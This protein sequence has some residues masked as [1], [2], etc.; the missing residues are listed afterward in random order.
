M[1]EI[2][3]VGTGDAFGSGGRRNSAILVRDRGRTLLLDCGPTTLGGLKALGIDPLELDAIAL[4]HF[5]G[6]HIAGVPFVLLDYLYE[7]PRSTPLELLGP[8]GV[9][10]RVA[11]L[12]RAY[13]YHLEETARYPL[14]FGEFTHDKPLD[15]AGFRITPLPAVHQEHTRPH[16]LRVDTS[17]RSLVFSGD[18][19]WHEALPD[20]VG[21]VDLFIS[22]CVF[23]EDEFAYHLSHRRL[24]AERRRF[25][26]GSIRL[27]HLGSQVL[28]NESRVR[29]DCAHDGLR[30]PV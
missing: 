3:F 23:F 14:R 25:R 4:S 10:D 22:E 24:D 9:A 8:P 16:M 26:C 7:H 2:V 15:V 5:H 27:T 29:F 30:I 21:D 19:G 6:D 13:D 1:A 18:T 28:A 17:A 20:K 11:Q 12:T